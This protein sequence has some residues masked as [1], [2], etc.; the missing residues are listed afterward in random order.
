M[1]GD[2]SSGFL[3]VR[4]GVGTGAV[5]RGNWAD[6][7]A[8]SLVHL[9]SRLVSVLMR[10]PWCAHCCPVLRK[11]RPSD[12]LGVSQAGGDPGSERL[13]LFNNPGVPDQKRT[14]T[15]EGEWLR[16]RETSRDVGRDHL[17]VQAKGPMWSNRRGASS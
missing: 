17:N 10:D 11:K 8:L 14:D 5:R 12:R 13:Y 4:V 9:D 16:E 3:V 6:S 7:F 1:A 15:K 2:G